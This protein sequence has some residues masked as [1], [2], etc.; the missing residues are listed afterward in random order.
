MLKDLVIYQR[1]QDFLLWIHS[2]VS[3][4]PRSEK[5][6]LGG[7]IE[8]LALTSLRSIIRANYEIKKME[9]LCRV[10]IDLEVLKV[11][12]RNAKIMGLINNRKYETAARSLL[13]IR[14]LLIGWMKS[15]KRRNAGSGSRSGINSQNVFGNFYLSLN[16]E[17]VGDE[18]QEAPSGDLLREEIK[19]LNQTMEERKT[20]KEAEGMPKKSREIQGVWL[21]PEV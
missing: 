16:S 3:N 15:E 2:I 6:N 9:T 11:L 4:F 17:Q 21:F 1:M 12:L 10:I 20:E 19:K 13:E 5:Y 14:K 18:V 7:E 8:R